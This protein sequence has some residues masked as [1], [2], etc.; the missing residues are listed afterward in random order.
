MFKIIPVAELQRLSIAELQELYQA[1][2]RELAIRNPG[3]A[4]AEIA[5]TNL[6]NIQL[7]LSWKLRV[8]HP[9]FFPG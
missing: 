8:R 3:P 9:G 2:Q 7:V 4:I 6:E 1:I 5:I